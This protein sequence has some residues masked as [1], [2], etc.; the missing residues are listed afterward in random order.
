VKS[1]LVIGGGITGLTAAWDASRAGLREVTLIERDQR[2]GGKIRTDSLDGYLLEQGPDSFLSNRPE[3][4]RLCEELGLAGRLAPRTP[5]RVSAYIMRRHSLYPLPD[6]FSSVAPADTAA[7]AASPLLS[8]TGRRRVLE[9]PAQPAA[10]GEED[11]SV[12]SFLTRR[13]GEEAFQ[14]LLEPLVAAI[15][16]GDAALL[17]AEAILP[18]LRRLERTRGVLTR[19]PGESASPRK[20]PAPFL[21]FPGGTGELAAALERGLAGITVLRGTGAVSLGRSPGG[22]VVELSSGT[23]LEAGAVILAAP[24]YEA[25]RL[26]QR[27][28]GELQERLSR[29]PFASTAVIHLAYR[30]S[31]VGHPLDGYG[32]LI[33]SIESSGLLACTWSSRKWE[34]RAPADRVLLRLFAGRFGGQ[35]AAGQPERELL[36]L[37]R[38]ELAATLGITARPVL[39]RLHPWTMA[40][41][42][43]TLG[44]LRRVE[45]VH[46]RAA[47]LPGLFLAGASYGGVGI[48]QC[49]ASGA[50]ASAA[51]REYLSLAQPG[52]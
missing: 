45:A 3:V 6:G 31:D 52:K 23:W 42:Q 15:H 34:G 39:E 44:H 48:P 4:V 20:P 35:D 8:E 22:Y 14:L 13:F 37:A 46:E 11:E 18:E 12:A 5:R 17:S 32:Y 26:V 1:L 30:C 40:M 10:A 50:A 38:D 47:A 43:Y 51:A 7:L 49:V 2:L 41:P 33:P 27:L 24:A 36:A 21:S 16:A 28:D 29:I 25:A 19:Q 9:E